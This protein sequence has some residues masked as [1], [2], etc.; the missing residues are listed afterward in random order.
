MP[1]RRPLPYALDVS[2]KNMTLGI[3]VIRYLLYAFR[4]L[5]LLYISRARKENAQNEANFAQNNDCFLPRI[6]I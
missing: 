6:L 4:R 1:R 5:F 2:T 3:L